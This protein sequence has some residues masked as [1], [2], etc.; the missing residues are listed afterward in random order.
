ME[1]FDLR[2]LIFDF[3]AAGAPDGLLV[4]HRRHAPNKKAAPCGRPDFVLG[5]GRRGLTRARS[6]QPAWAD[7]MS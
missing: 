3:E 7:G 6:R 1:I 4:R 2:F 5:N